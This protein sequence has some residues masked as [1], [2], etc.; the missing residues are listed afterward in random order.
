MR[1]RLATALALALALALGAAAPAAAQLSVSAQV[2]RTQ[3]GLDDQVV[4]AV[5]VSGPQA[6]LP[7]PQLPALSNFS[8]YSSGRSQN[9]SFVNG[10]V[11]SSVTHTFVLVPRAVGKGLIP[12]I[13]VSAQ[14]ASAQTEPI[15]IQVVPPA[16]AAAAAPAG[17]PG[18]APARPRPAP[19]GAGAPDVMVVAELDKPRAFVNEQVTLSVKFYAAVP[20]MGNPEYV[21]PKL[22]GFLG[23]DLPPLRHYDAEVK[24]RSYGVT[25]I[26]TALFPLQ[27]GRLRIGSAVVR[28]HVQVDPSVDPFSPDFFERFFSQG[29]TA[30]Q[31]RTV[32][33]QPLVL[34]VLP[35]PPQ[36]RPAG[37]AGAVGRFSVS[38]AVDKD[39][40]K[41]GD[42]VNLSV[43]VQGTGNL[44][45]MGELA[46]PALPS[47][48]V[49]E[50]ATSVNQ[51]KQGDLVQGSKV[52]RTVLVPRVSGDLAVPA[53]PFTYFDPAR[54]EY[55]QARSAPLSVSVA[56]GDPGPASSPGYGAPA[57]PAAPGLT[58]V[59]EDIAYLKSGTAAPAATRLLEAAAAA[60]PVHALPF[61]FLGWAAG[62]AFYRGRLASDPQG[63]RF[64]AAL[65]RARSRLHQA[66]RA[67]DHRQAAGLMSEALVNFLAD[68]LAEPAAGL[69]MRR[70]A[71][72]L[73][74]RQPGIPGPTIERI[75]AVWGELDS[76]RF[77][78]PSAG[79]GGEGASVHDELAALFRD[80][81][82]EL[83][84]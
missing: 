66:Q 55:V 6:S 23:E 65:K 24:G 51:Q 12:P 20:L 38:A 61:L 22:E 79:P 50:P 60:G 53:I 71:E 67:A 80:L 10:R 7:D 84:R 33:S 76:R 3:V 21:P 62:S 83:K 17:A 18:T 77:A 59:N 70:V 30:P 48:R 4:L 58:R 31:A 2:N 32:A 15:E 72:L 29:I 41:V 39:R 68:K 46:L 34:E 14:G 82:K 16:G 78:P 35:L 64:R 5:T 8:V 11:S 81:E 40:A 42:A 28:C 54:R 56:P 9:I 74:S 26:K 73:Q 25:E 57:A 47:W 63:A 52:I 49:F 45:A 27:A 75:R 69:T 19:A 13:A 37:F 36:G 43:S 44:K 1:L